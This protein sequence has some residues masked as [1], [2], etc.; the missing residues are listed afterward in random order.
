MALP[1]YGLLDVGDIGGAPP[2]PP[3]PDASPVLSVNGHIGAVVLNPADIGLANVNNTSDAAKPISTATAAA[4]TT[5]SD[6]LT[7][8]GAQL[9]ALQ[10]GGI[11][12]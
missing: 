9:L 4:L 11:L 3:A 7:S 6:T 8:H 10:G 2:T 5:I 1:V 12:D